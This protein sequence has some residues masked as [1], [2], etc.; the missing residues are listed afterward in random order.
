MRIAAAIFCLLIPGSAL[1]R[2]NLAPAYAFVF[3]ASAEAAHSCAGMAQNETQ[4]NR[5]MAL[6]D[7]NEGDNAWLGQQFNDL[8]P[9]LQKAFLEKGAA[10]WCAS[11]WELIGPS[12]DFKALR[13]R[14]PED[15]PPG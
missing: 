13:K 3:A 1:A 2:N 7:V 5:F 15:G 8:K 11:I 14:L 4:L 9:K 10:E 12:S 6:A